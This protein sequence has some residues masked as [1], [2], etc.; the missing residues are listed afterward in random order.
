MEAF[1]VRH[2]LWILTD[3]ISQRKDALARQVTNNLHLL[4]LFA[5][6]FFVIHALMGHVKLAPKILTEPFPMG[7]AY[8][9]MVLL[10]K[11]IH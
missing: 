9:K 8:V 5:V 2:V 7:N 1:V 11:T 6:V 4:Q 3:K 10:L